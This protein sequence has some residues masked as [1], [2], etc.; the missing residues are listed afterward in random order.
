[1]PA[2]CGVGAPVTKSAALTSV[3]P[4][5]RAEE[6]ALAVPAALA[7][8]KVSPL[9]PTR[10]TI[11][12]RSAAPS[13]DGFSAVVPDASHTVNAEPLMATLPVASGVGSG[14]VPPAPWACWTR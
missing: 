7:V 6:V 5:V 8:S 2:D 9:T 10:S 1:M 3:S 12:S 13:A 14:A 11:P 4:A